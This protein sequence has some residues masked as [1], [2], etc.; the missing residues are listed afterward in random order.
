MK[1]LAP[2]DY[3]DLD[4]DMFIYNSDDSFP[5]VMGKDKD[6]QLRMYG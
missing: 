2:Q 1:E 6:K 3:Q 5:K 4:S